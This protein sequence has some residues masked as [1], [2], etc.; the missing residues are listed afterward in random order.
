[1]K[2]VGHDKCYNPIWIKGFGQADWRGLLHSVNRRDFLRFVFYIAEQGSEEFRKCTELAQRSITSSTFIIDMEGLSMKQ[3]AHRPRELTK[4]CLRKFQSKF[5]YNFSCWTVQVRDIGLE[6]I[7]VLEANYPEVIRK[8]FII[9]GKF[10]WTGL[11]WLDLFT[12]LSY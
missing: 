6:A 3:I 9:N 1:M 2:V 7:K 5:N 8:V 4:I 10:H 11:T 12:V